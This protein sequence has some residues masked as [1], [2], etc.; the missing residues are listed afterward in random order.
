MKTWLGWLTA[1]LWLKSTLATQQLAAQDSAT[2]GSVDLTFA[3]RR[4]SSGASSF[5][6]VQ[7]LLPHSEGHLLVAG[8]FYTPGVGSNL[9]RLTADG[10][11]D[12]TFAPIDF[13][14]V[15]ALALQSD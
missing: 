9:V 8:R 1:M 11:Y 12:P 2:P 7:F 10:A 14:A 6:H 4:W 13:G 3:A 5:Y 15:T